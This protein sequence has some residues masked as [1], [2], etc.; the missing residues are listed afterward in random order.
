MWKRWL[1]SGGGGRGITCWHE[2][3]CW[4]SSI[5]LTLH[6]S[7]DF[8]PETNYIRQSGR[9]VTQLQP[10]KTVKL[11]LI[12]PLLQSWGLFY[13]LDSS[14]AMKVIEKEA[15]S[16][17]AFEGAYTLVGATLVAQRVRIC[18]PFGTPRIDSYFGQIPRIRKGQP[19]PEFL[20]GEIHG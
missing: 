11:H 15:S 17:P 2:S 4:L 20:P 10:H 5:L 7:P 14:Q 16:T 18:L 13:L 6:P 12:V 1:N 9:C 19:T 8:S 3:L